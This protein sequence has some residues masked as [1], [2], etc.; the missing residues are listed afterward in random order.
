MDE[1]ETHD[2][3]FYCNECEGVEGQT[4]CTD[5]CRCD[6]CVEALADQQEAKNDRD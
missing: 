6:T 3:H 4:E 2:Q 1:D 5:E